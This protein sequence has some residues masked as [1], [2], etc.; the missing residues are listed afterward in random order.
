MV[1]LPLWKIWKSVGMM[2]F[3][4][5]WKKTHVPNHQPGFS[6]ILHGIL[7]YRF[8]YAW[9]QF[10]WTWYSLI[11]IKNCMFVSKFETPNQIRLFIS[12][13]HSPRKKRNEV[14]SIIINPPFLKKL[15]QPSHIVLFKIYIT[16]LWKCGSE[17]EQIQR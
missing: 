14:V 17:N 7:L 10:C 3:S 13:H 2:T 15:M 16:S 5:E 1:F 8:R 9:E 4:T 6:E 12:Y 11:K